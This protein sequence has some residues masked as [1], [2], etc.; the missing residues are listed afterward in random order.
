MHKA[1]AA[2]QETRD[3]SAADDASH[4]NN[5]NFDVP[6]LPPELQGQI[7]KK[8]REAYTELVTEPVPD[9]FLQLLQQLKNKEAQEQGGGQ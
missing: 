5:L 7:G 9:K 4:P 6:A 3:M 1:R 8:L 2:R